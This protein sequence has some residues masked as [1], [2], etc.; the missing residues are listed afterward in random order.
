[1]YLLTQKRKMELHNHNSTEL[2]SWKIL[3]LSYITPIPFE[4]K[5]KPFVKLRILWTFKLAAD[6]HFTCPAHTTEA[7]DIPELN[8]VGV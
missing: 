7:L 6:S 8:C 5:S 2:L 3:N 1:M 4:Y